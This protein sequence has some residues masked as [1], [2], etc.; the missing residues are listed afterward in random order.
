MSNM[1]VQH[2][3]RGGRQASALRRAV[4]SRRWLHGIYKHSCSKNRI[5]SNPTL[6]NDIKEP[7]EQPIIISCTRKF[8]TDNYNSLSLEPDFILFVFKLLNWHLKHTVA[9]NAMV[10]AFLILAE[11]IIEGEFSLGA[12]WLRR[13]SCRF[14]TEVHIT[15]NKKFIN[16]A[17]MTVKQTPFCK[18]I[19]LTL[20]S[21]E[22]QWDQVAWIKM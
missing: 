22:W 3:K 15:L 8:W 13:P 9:T 14:N 4:V 2:F 5:H 19:L 7:S 21:G 1:F 17:A 11:G 6:T 16:E 12:L 10:R 20:V 18:N